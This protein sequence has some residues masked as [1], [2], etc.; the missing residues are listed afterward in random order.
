M[1]R[2]RSGISV[3]HEI[4]KQIMNSWSD[5]RKNLKEYTGL[6]SSQR[7]GASLVIPTLT[8]C[9]NLSTEKANSHLGT[10]LPWPFSGI[11]VL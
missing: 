7:I 4:L 5:D 9:M 2:Q 6:S 3:W 10:F 8:T 1:R 11:P